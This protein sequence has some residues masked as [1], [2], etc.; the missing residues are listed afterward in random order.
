[1]YK[2]IP[3]YLSQELEPEYLSQGMTESTFVE[4]INKNEKNMV[5]GWIYNHPKTN[6]S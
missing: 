6:N 2:H 1:M 4:I 5:A 3:E